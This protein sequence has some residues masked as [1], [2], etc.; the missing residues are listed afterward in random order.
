MTRSGSQPVNMSLYN[1]VKSEAKRKFKVWPS[2]YASG[3]LVAEYKRRGGKYR[4]Y[5][6]SPKT[7]TKRSPKTRTKRSPKTRTKRSPN[8]KRSSG[9]AR[10]FEE[11]WIDVCKLP[12]IVPCGR[13]KSSW[14]NYPYCRPLKRISSKTPR[15]A[16]E[17][18]QAEIQRKCRQKKRS[19]RLKVH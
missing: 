2:A 3:W 15:T 14:K 18:S 7:R 19:P 1:R 4:G 8:R 17:L 5:Q 16:R 12:R 6:S 10:W 9:I 11:K 13:K